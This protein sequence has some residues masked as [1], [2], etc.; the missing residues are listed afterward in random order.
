MKKELIDKK[1]LVPDKSKVLIF[2]YKADG[3]RTG[4]T[5][6]FRELT[7]TTISVINKYQVVTFNLNEIVGIQILEPRRP[8]EV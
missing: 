4:V 3:K 5:G 6:L 1:K 7:D 8:K 2:Y